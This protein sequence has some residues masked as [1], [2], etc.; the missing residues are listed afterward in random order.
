MTF[1]RRPGMDVQAFRDYRRDVH[2]PILLGIPEMRL[3]RRLV[4]S[5]PLMSSDGGEEPPFDAMIEIWFG[6]RDE[7]DELFQSENF[8]A[9]VNPDHANFVDLTTFQSVVTEELVDIE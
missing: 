6:S 1:K 8:Q 9:K 7:M 4:V 2:V 5:Y 3:A